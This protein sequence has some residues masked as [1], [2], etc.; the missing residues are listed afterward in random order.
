MVRLQNIVFLDLFVKGV[1]NESREKDP[2]NASASRTCK[3]VTGKLRLMT[4][5]S[6]VRL[7][8]SMSKELDSIF[9]GRR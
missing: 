7:T 1:L 2:S 8:A 5:M 3:K 4:A 6:R 9:T